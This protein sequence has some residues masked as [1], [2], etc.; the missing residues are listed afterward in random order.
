[1]QA[2][3]HKYNDSS[4]YEAN[5]KATILMR[6]KE[7]MEG[8]ERFSSLAAEMIDDWQLKRK[9]TCTRI[10]AI[11]DWMDPKSWDSMLQTAGRPAREMADDAPPQTAQEPT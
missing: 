4:F 2:Y 11:V 6:T 9:S 7:V 5:W 3:R 8:S 1:M 10:F